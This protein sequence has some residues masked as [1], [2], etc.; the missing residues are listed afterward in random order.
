MFLFFTLQM[1]WCCCSLYVVVVFVLLHE[2]QAHTTSF[3]EG[4]G[5]T[6]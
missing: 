3:N 6:A 4:S 1:Q 5:P 2:A